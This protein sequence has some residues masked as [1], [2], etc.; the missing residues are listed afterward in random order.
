MTV[1]KRLSISDTNPDGETKRLIKEVEYVLKAQTGADPVEAG[2]EILAALGHRRA[3][4]QGR[5]ACDEADG[6]AGG[7][8]VDAGKGVPRHS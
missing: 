4:Q 8:A 2:D 6:I 5:A 1:A 3:A 7:V